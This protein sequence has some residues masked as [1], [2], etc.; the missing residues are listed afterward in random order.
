MNTLN[1]LLLNDFKGD[2]HLVGRSGGEIANRKV[3]TDI[4]Q[5]PEGVDLAIFTLPVASVKEALEDCVRRKVKAVVI[6]ASG[7]A[8]AGERARQDEISRIAREGGIALLG[9]NCFGYTNFVDSFPVGFVAA[10]KLPPPR[11]GRDPCVAILSHSG[12]L[13]SHIRSGLET[14]DIPPSYTI[15]TGNEA[16]IGLDD[17]IDF[18]VADPHTRLIVAYV[19]EVRKPQEFLA[20]ARRAR[21]AGKPVVMLHPGRTAAATEAVSSHTG[22]LAGNHAVMR[23]VVEHAGIVFVDSIDELID[24]AEVLARYPDPLPLG[25]GI[26]TFSGAL[27]AVYH[28]FCAEIGLPVPP[29]SVEAETVLRAALPSFAT[30]RNP[31]DLTTQ[32]IWQPELMNVGSKALLDDPGT[33]SL[34]LSIPIGAPEL[35][36]KYLN[37]LLAAAKDC[38]KPV[39]FSPLG[40]RTPLPQAM[41]DVA[42]E[43]RVI[44]S[45]SADRA[46]RALKQVYR[47]GRA[48][49]RAGRTT[50]VAPAPEFAPLGAGPQPEWLAKKMLAAAGVRVPAGGLARTADEAVAIA[51]RIGFPV[52]MKAQAARLMH[53]S[54][55]AAVFLD[56]ADEDAVRSC[57]IRLHA[58]VRDYDASIELDGVLIEAMVRRGLEMVVGAKRDPRWGPVLLVGIGGVL[59]E[60]IGDVILLPPDLSPEAIRDEL[61]TLKTAALLG[62]FRGTPAVDIGAVAA[63]AS[64]LGAIMSARPDILEVD[65]NPLIAH[66]IGEGATALDALIVMAE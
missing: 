27:C 65:I 36:V 38:P 39:I 64:S 43:N 11:I 56:I 30:P 50:T 9:P 17:C 5:L 41:L 34:L 7:F 29:L 44:V 59:I 33:G 19:E 21:A 58:N 57:W 62:G 22:A 52:V 54:E 16:G 26:L 40:D 32:P 1:N 53:K 63:V 51:R 28:D 49:Q 13:M 61:A 42:R 18:L 2:I 45:R 25:P 46:L 10:T 15:S 23:T 4:S 66:P 35:A 24:A 20:A 3:L 31:L 47:H 48:L 8:E 37:H 14:R 6:F 60:A 55:A 12:G